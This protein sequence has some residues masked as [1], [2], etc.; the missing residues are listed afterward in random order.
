M[1]TFET[2]TSVYD[3]LV[4]RTI[5]IMGSGTRRAV[6]EAVIAGADYARHTHPHKRR[7]GRLTGAEL[8]GRLIRGDDDGAEGELVNET[9]Y[10]RFVEFPTRPH[11]IFPKP[12][13][14][15]L[16]FTVGGRT[17]FA[18]MVRHPGTPGFPFMYP[19]AR[20]A[21]EQIIFE[22]EHVTFTLAAALWD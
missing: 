2:D 7:T 15:A 13:N 12:G 22:T 18:T 8:H 16:R 1:L 11:L 14:R 5:D 19:A 10:A 9:P 4:E 3:G 6:H 21:G 17:V 20:Y